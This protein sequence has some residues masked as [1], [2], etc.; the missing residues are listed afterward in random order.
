MGWGGGE[1]GLDKSQSTIFY[2]RYLR[3]RDRMGLLKFG[4]SSRSHFSLKSLS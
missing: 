2:S 4:K 3:K 1:M